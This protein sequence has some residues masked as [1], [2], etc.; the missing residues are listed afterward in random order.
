M[1]V[2]A[3]VSARR[4]QRRIGRTLEVLVDSVNGEGAVARS[5]ADA[6]EIDGVVRIRDGASLRPGQFARV[7]V[8]AADAHD[9]QARLAESA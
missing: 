4:L 7:V 3:E 2:Q 9:L 6:P 8:E 5:A 1:A